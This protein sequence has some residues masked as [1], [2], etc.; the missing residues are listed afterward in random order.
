VIESIDRISDRV[1]D[2]DTGSKRPET[3]DR[4]PEVD[5][6]LEISDCAADFIICIDDQV[7]IS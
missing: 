6:S 3:E 1:P 7:S 2:P 5:P 4:M